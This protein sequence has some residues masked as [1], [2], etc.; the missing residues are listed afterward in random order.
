MLPCTASQ[1][2]KARGAMDTSNVKRLTDYDRKILKALDVT[3]A[4]TTSE[5]A[6]SVTPE[7]GGNRRRHAGAIRSWLAGLER[8]GMVKRID[9]ATPQRR[10]K[11][12]E[13]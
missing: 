13:T 11:V 5:V 8:Q 9:A 3:T 2:G 1:Q 10:L 6:R 4:R 12:N 7:F